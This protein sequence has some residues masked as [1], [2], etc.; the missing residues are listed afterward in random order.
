MSKYYSRTPPLVPLKFRVIWFVFKDVVSCS[1]QSKTIHVLPTDQSILS[2]EIE[3]FLHEMKANTKSFFR[4][5]FILFSSSNLYLFKLFIIH[6]H[7]IHIHIIHI[8]GRSC[9]LYTL[10]MVVSEL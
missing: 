2:K 9:V 4:E 5:L 8:A 10:K 3:H 7:I 1:I 6:I